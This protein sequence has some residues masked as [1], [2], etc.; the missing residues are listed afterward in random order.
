MGRYGG[1]WPACGPLSWRGLAAQ[2]DEALHVV[3]EIGKADLRALARRV[4]TA[5]G[6]SGGFLRWM[7]ETRPRAASHASFF[8]E[9]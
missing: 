7:R 8:A 6:R 4:R 3:G 2:P 5:I 9:R 1:G